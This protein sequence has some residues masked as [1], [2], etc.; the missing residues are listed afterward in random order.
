MSRPPGRTASAACRNHRQLRACEGREIGLASCASGCRDRGAPFRV[1]STAHRRTRCRTPTRTADPLRDRPART[2]I[3]RAPL[4]STVSRRSCD[5][6][7]A[8]VSGDD[9]RR[10][11]R[12]S[13]PW[14][15]SCRRRRARVEHAH[16]GLGA[17]SSATS[18]DASSCR[19]NWPVPASGVRSGFPDCDDETIRRVARRFDLDA[20]LSREPRR[21]SQLSLFSRFTRSVSG[22][23]VLLNCS[24]ASA[25]VKSITIEPSARKPSQDARATLPDRGAASPSGGRG[26]K[27]Q[28]MR[29]SRDG[30]QHRVHQTCGA[31]FPRA[32]SHGDRIV[33][34]RRCRHAIEVKQLIGAE[35]QNLQHL[36][37]ELRRRAAWRSARSDDRAGAAIAACR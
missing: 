37:V 31:R 10:D 35:S 12:P 5:A 7:A 29:I 23:A 30:P 9:L 32:P 8:N 22:A 20:V 21:A 28:P 33:H 26:G 36:E 15:S 34:R 25:A 2:R 24:Q 3:F 27:R 1:P 19:K 4:A 14:P 16:A 13:P 17:P 11:R 6:R 18:C